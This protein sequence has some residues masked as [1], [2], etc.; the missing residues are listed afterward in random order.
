MSD[1][2]DDNDDYKKINNEEELEKLHKRFKRLINKKR[3]ESFI[4]YLKE[5][6]NNNLQS[7]VDT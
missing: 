5:E 1:D 6:S 2:N 4:R 3:L 7:R